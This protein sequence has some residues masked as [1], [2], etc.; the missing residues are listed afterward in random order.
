MEYDDPDVVRSRTGRCLCS[1]DG[2]PPESK[3]H[4]CKGFPNALEEHGYPPSHHLIAHHHVVGWRP[5][6]ELFQGQRL[7][8]APVAPPTQH[9]GSDAVPE[10]LRNGVRGGWARVVAFQPCGKRGFRG[11]HGGRVLSRSPWVV[12][13]EDASILL[14]GEDG[15]TGLDLSFSTHLFLLKQIKDPA[16]EAQIISR[17]NRMG[18]TGSVKVIKMSVNEVSDAEKERH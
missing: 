15:S 1:D 7:E 17:A 4:K 14:L 3:L 13:D 2:C 9:H 8:V 11:W 6:M 10:L 12:Q 18:A 5:N 16:L